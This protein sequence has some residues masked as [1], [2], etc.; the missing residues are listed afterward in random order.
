MAFGDTRIQAG[1]IVLPSRVL[2]DIGGLSRALLIPPFTGLLPTLLHAT[3]LMLAVFPCFVSAR[4]LCWLAC[5]SGWRLCWSNMSGRCVVPPLLGFF[6]RCS[7]LPLW[8][9]Q[10][11]RALCLLVSC[12]D[13][14]ATRGGGCVG[15]ICRV[16]V[17][18]PLY[19]AS[20]HAAPCYPLD[21]CSLPVLC[22]CSYIVLTGL[23]LGVAVVLVCRPPFTG[24]LPTLLHSTPWMLAVFPCC[25]VSARI[26]CWLACCSGWR[27]CWCNMSGRCVDP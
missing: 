27:L 11:S 21:A 14:P 13:W 9:L 15:V 25:F 19:W 24:L 16:G 1:F 12:A 18:S 5:C 3:P 23:L 22:V 17:S 8:C 26:L 6:P 2:C 4:L 10:S 20:S 7:M